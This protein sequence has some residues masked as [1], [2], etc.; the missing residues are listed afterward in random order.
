MADVLGVGL[1]R[2]DLE[3]R[4]DLLNSLVFKQ[5]LMPTDILV[6]ST[7]EKYAGGMVARDKLIRSARNQLERLF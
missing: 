1:N 3:I 4:T 7:L 2:D 5:K 6:K